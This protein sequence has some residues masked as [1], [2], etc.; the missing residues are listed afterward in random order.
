[1][2]ELRARCQTIAARTL[3]LE[4]V[5]EKT[6]ADRSTDAVRAVSERLCCTSFKM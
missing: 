1:M 2:A 3:E 4:A 5:L 6:T